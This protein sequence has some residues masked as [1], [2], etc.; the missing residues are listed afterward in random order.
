VT[1]GERV[2]KAGLV[3][4]PAFA[5]V[6]S[7]AGIVRA[8]AQLHVSGMGPTHGKAIVESGKIETA[9]DLDKAKRASH[10]TALNL[11]AQIDAGLRVT[12]GKIF[13]LVNAGPDFTALDDAIE[14]ARKVFADLFGHP[15][16]WT[17]V[18]SPCLPFAITTEME[19]IFGLED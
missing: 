5:P 11:L 8:G 12:P 10:L 7:Y 14:P 4:P 17:I 9:A 18:G 15:G 13:A 1:L 6:A 3:L 2:A 16:V 19:A